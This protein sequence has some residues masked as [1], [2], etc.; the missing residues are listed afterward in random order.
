MPENLDDE[1]SV[2]GLSHVLLAALEHTRSAVCITTAELDQP[3]PRIV[4]VNPAYL[5]MTGRERGSVSGAT[6][7]IMQG[8]LTD[9]KVLDQLRDD[10]MHGRS[11]SGQ[12]VNY[13]GDKTPFMIEWSID[14][15]GSPE[16]S[17]THFV[18]AQE[19]VTEQV[20]A[21][22]LLAAEQE[23]DRAL[24]EL[25]DSRLSV[26]AAMQSMVD[27]VL[28]AAGTIAMF[29][30]V[31]VEVSFDDR[32]L[33]S[34]LVPGGP[35]TDRISFEIGQPP[36][37]LSGTIGVSVTSPD[38]EAILDRDGLVRFA[39]RVG[40]VLAG[41]AEYH[42]QRTTA[43]RLQQ[44]LLPDPPDLEGFETVAHYAPAV[45]GLKVGGDWFDTSDTG[46]R[47]V[48]SVGDVSGKGVDAA[49]LM[50]RLRLVAEVEL[51]RGVAVPQV[52]RLLDRIC[53]DG[54]EMATLLTVEIDRAD[55]R[56]VVRSAGHLPPLVLGGGRARVAW[57]DPAPPLGYMSGAEIPEMV[58]E[59]D[60]GDT[61]L[62]FT[63]GLVERRDEDLA[64]S[65]ERL[66]S[67]LDPDEDL[68]RLVEGT[69]EGLSTAAEDDIAILAIRIGAPADRV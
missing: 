44:G 42:R 35:E 1:G 57:S 7:R 14:P 62:M 49:V 18:A 69:V 68:T 3:G 16:G 6:P 47:I 58:L 12:T 63:D 64:T 5:K 52:M 31:D 33:T 10:L 2:T 23:L 39:V 61:L 67:T 21:L 41:L 30:T 8:P 59:L 48:L 40:N 17:I 66:V 25:L 50:G 27:R 60:P 65:L 56:A 54:R 20:R 45:T 34:G 46:E 11:F 22:N 32:V 13:R 15:V 43:L 19:D 37:G 26:D 28:S 55:R 51:E 4:Y 38:E 36:A 24:V 53:R 9:R 29:G